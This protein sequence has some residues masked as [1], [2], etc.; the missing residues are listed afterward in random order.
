MQ[1]EEGRKLTI[2]RI[3]QEEEGRKLTINRI[4]PRG[5]VKAEAWW[6]GNGTFQIS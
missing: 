4:N 5:K 1:E 2:N 3:I 6:E